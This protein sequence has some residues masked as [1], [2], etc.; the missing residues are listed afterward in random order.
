MSFLIDAYEGWSAAEAVQRFKLY[1][2]YLEKIKGG[3]PESAFKFASA[4]WHYQFQDRHCPHDGW[5]EHLK[6]WESA[7]GES[8]EFRQT[9]IDVRLLGAFHEAHLELN[10]K[11]VRSY[12]LNAQPNGKQYGNQNTWHGDWLIDEVRLSENNLVLHE[13]LF[14]N[15]SRWLIEASDFL[16]EWKPLK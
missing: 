7:S 12:T 4:P 14:R 10:Y 15:R 9:Q 1:A 5:V 16:W 13:I 6:I 3:L 2:E 8:R 11:D